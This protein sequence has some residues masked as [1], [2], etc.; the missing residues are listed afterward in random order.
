MKCGLAPGNLLPVAVMLL[1]LSGCGKAHEEVHHDWVIRARLVFMS[2][3]LSSERPPLP[4][5]RL[6]LVFPYIAG[7]LYGAPTTGDFL[8]P[9]IGADYRFEIDLNRSQPLLL[10]SLEPTDFSLSFL[11]I[12]PPAARI[13]RL[14]PMALQVDGIEQI[15]R[16]DWVD[17]RSKQRLLLVYLDR[18]ARITGGTLTKGR[19]LRYD[20]Q[21]ALP[22]YVWIGRQTDS[23]GEVYRVIPKP[24]ELI[25]AVTPATDPP[26][27]A[28]RARTDIPGR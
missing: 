22:G 14:A 1:G 3:D 15:G 11:R 7:D 4:L 5:A 16:T 26:T 27:A 25:L 6:R 18:A 8:H 28:S 2:E 9:A 24:A 13:A 21:S 19:S 17:P 10:A 12:D 23:D 20:I